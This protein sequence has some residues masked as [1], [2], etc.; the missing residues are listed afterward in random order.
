MKLR[1][2]LS[3]AVFQIVAL[4][5]DNGECP[6]IGYLTELKASDPKLHEAMP[7]RIKFRA[8]NLSIT[9]KNISRPIQG[10]RYNGMFRLKAKGE[11]L[12]YCYLPNRVVVLLSGYNKNDIQETEWERARGYV[13]DLTNQMN[14]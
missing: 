7:A 13:I 1:H 14:Q 11:R 6:A 12:L 4:E 2:Q 8:S 9:N 10:A 3:G 5:L